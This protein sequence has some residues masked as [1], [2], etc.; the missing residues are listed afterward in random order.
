MAAQ[1]KAVSTKYFKNKILEE[2]IDSKCLLCKEH[3]ETIDHLTSGCSNL[4]KNEYMINLVYICITQ[5]AKP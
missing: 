1:D 4:A 5:Y 2:G 3:E